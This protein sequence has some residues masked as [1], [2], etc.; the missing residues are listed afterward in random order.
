MEKGKIVQFIFFSFIF[1][2]IFFNVNSQVLNNI[3]KLSD[4]P[5]RYNHFSFNSDGDMI[6]DIESYPKK[7]ERKFFGIRKDGRKLFLNNYNVED[8]YYNLE[9]PDSVKRVEGE[10]FFVKV[11]TN[12]ISNSYFEEYIIGIS[13]ATNQ[14]KTEFYYLYKRK[15]ILKYYFNSSDIFG[16]IYSLVFSILPDPLNDS[17]NNDYYISYIAT[18]SNGSTKFITIKIN[19]QIT[20][21]SSQ[22]SYNKESIEEFECIKQYVTSC[23]FTKNNIYICFYASNESKLIIRAFDILRS[24]TGFSTIIHTFTKD[25]S[26]R[27]TKGILFKNEIGFFSYFKDKGNNPTFCLYNINY[28]NSATIYKSYGEIVFTQGSF[29]NRHLHNDLIKLNDNNICFLG[30]SS[31]KKEINILI[32]NFYDED[33]FMNIR[34][35]KINVM[36]ENGITI[37]ADLKIYLYNNFLVL[38]MSH[39]FQE[40]CEQDETGKGYFSSL[41]FF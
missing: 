14:A 7:T 35:Y 9:V 33:N 1:Q 25:Y 32:F 34:Y 27:F 38:A 10:S 40:I 30:V 41:I 11:K 20:I 12:N 8:Y 4:Y 37:Y 29:S 2:L 19:F 21:L 5:Y 17:V 39:C 26:P 24:R 36:E 3:I 28:N 13:K 15:L 31:N 23:F 6:V 18:L 22:L 16:N